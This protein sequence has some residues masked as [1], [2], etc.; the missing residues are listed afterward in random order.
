MTRWWR[1]LLVAGAT[2]GAAA[3]SD[4]GNDSC[5]APALPLQN[6]RAHALGET[7]YLPQTQGECA[8]AGW[9]VALA[10]AESSALV[11]NEGAPEPRFTPDIPGTYQFQLAGVEG[12]T[13]D[14]TVVNRPYDKRFRNH[15][16][17]PMFGLARDGEMLWTANG[18]TY[19]VSRLEK[20]DAGN[21]TKKLEIPVG[22]WPGAL[23]THDSQSY[24]VVANRGSDTLGFINKTTGVLEDA[25]W[26][27]DEPTGLAIAPDGKRVYVTLPT[28]RQV[29]VVDLEARQVLARVDL[30]LDPRALALSLDGSTLFVAAHRSGNKAADTFGTYGSGDDGDLWFVNTVTFEVERRISDIA[31]V[32]RAIA[33]SPD[34]KELALVGTDA[35]PTISQAGGDSFSHQ[36][37]VVGTDPSNNATYGTVITRANLR[38]TPTAAP[39][40]NPG[41][42][43]VTNDAIWVASEASS[44][45]VKLDR[46]NLAEVGRVNVGDGARHL[47]QEADGT[48]VVHCFESL[49]VWRL[50]PTTLAVRQSLTVAT[51]ARP[52]DVVLG[53]RVFS[54][55]GEAFAS[56]HGCASCHVEALNEGMVWN[57][58]PGDPPPRA[59]VRPLQLLGATTPQG[60]NAY[61]SGADN[62]SYQ[63]PGSIVASPVG[64]EEARGLRAF[65][66]SLVGA[67]AATGDTRPDGS[68]TDAAVRGQALFN[69]KANC[70]GCHQPPLYT[71]RQVIPVGKSDEPADV[72]TLLGV[73]RFGT[74]FVKGQAKTMNAAVDR[75]LEYSGGQLSADEKA[76]L[77]AFLRQLTVKGGA[78]LE[79]WPDID[80]DSAVYPNVTPWILFDSDLDTTLGDVDALASQYVV[81]ETE[82]GVPVAGTVTVVDRRITF[83]PSEPLQGG[84]TYRFRIL[85]GLPFL[86]GGGLWGTLESEFTVASDPQ[87]PFANAMT[88]T[89]DVPSAGPRPPFDVVLRLDEYNGN[90]KRTGAPYVTVVPQTFPVAQRQNVWFRIDGS[91][92]VM[93]AFAL[94]FG[95]G[96]QAADAN[97]VEGTL[98][99]EGP[100]AG[101]T[102]ERTVI[103][104]TLRLTAPGFTLVDVPFTIV[105]I[106]TP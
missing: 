88:M 56:N 70:S 75:A 21:Y 101:V 78:P 55:P 14:L 52:A 80:S 30:G 6:P 74:Y 35:D 100:D 48:V 60:W 61:T 67:P 33:L 22:A 1:L 47:V 24:V 39:V 81:L 94:P 96:G 54:R 28:M 43:L 50:E 65:L 3:C 63:G 77:V 106:P 38:P 85:A 46:A 102:P 31:S 91:Q 93:Q 13:F 42:V 7:F 27:G 105:P 11:F 17:T 44:L 98:K 23:V 32:I 86:A 5:I 62:F 12:A 37:V 87:L 26:V 10:P 45:V 29:A 69:G 73:Y 82:A 53:Q 9:Q 20:D 34:G 64:P 40:V 90:E 72:P 71:S 89:V 25:L 95:P 19:S 18:S 41:G 58:G 68:L 99:I 79:M 97:R 8:G 4:D 57:F 49:G 103:E 59:N 104:G 16:L 76:D 92:F 84:T 66:N 51:E 83:T 36:V 2:L 15:F